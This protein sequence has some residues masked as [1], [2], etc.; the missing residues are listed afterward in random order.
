MMRSTCA[1]LALAAV[2]RAAVK[3]CDTSDTTVACAAHGLDE[4]PKFHPKTTKIDVS[5]NNI[6]SIVS[7]EWLKNRHR[8]DW[9]SP[10]DS[11]EFKDVGTGADAYVAYGPEGK[12]AKGKDEVVSAPGDTVPNIPQT[13]NEALTAFPTEALE[14]LSAIYELALSHNAITAIPPLGSETGGVGFTDLGILMLDGNQLTNL[15]ANTFTGLEASLRQLSLRNNAITAL[16]PNTFTKE[17][18]Q[19]M[20]LDLRQN[21]V[22]SFAVNFIT[23][24]LAQ[25]GT[26]SFMFDEDSEFSGN[27]LACSS[28]TASGFNWWQTIATRCEC[29][30]GHSAYAATASEFNDVD[31]SNQQLR[32]CR[33][34]ATTLSEIEALKVL[35]TTME[36]KVTTIEGFGA[37]LATMATNTAAIKADL[38]NIHLKLDAAG[39]PKIGDRFRRDMN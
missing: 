8:R 9:T 37:T 6:V 34:G 39:C 27:V 7:K 16:E 19:L 30:P 21:N 17:F 1:L 35:L 20:H 14:C 38:G 36:G 28:Q 2:S 22:A 31:A 11:T 33:T 10:C 13:H 18:S 12:D 29:N 25:L 23:G 3:K 15:P 24:N 26:A 32:V 4:L 5:R